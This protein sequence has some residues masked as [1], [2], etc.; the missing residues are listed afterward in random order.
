MAD[1]IW[2]G[3]IYGVTLTV[4]VYC[5]FLVLHRQIRWLHPLF[6]TSFVIIL[7]VLCTDSLEQYQVGGEWFTFML[8]PATIALGVPLYKN[9]RKIQHQFKPILIG[10]MIGSMTGIVSAALIMFA[11]KASEQ[12]ILSMIPKSVT[13]PVSIEIAKLLGGIPEI[14]AV[15][16]VIAGLL[17]SMFGPMMLRKLGIQHETAIGTALGTASHGI[18]TGRMIQESERGGAISGLSMGLSAIVTSVYMIPL[19]IW[20]GP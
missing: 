20:F 2:H 14:T 7:I 9:F 16:T 13:T 5:I 1:S 12:L 18:G 17:G 11:F 19:Y 10:I 8:G 6:F 15:F 4:I 3:P